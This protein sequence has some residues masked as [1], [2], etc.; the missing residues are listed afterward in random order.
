MAAFD[1]TPK[2]KIIPGPSDWGRTAFTLP[3]ADQDSQHVE[4]LRDL[5]REYHVQLRLDPIDIHNNKWQSELM[6][7]VYDASYPL[8][9]VFAMKTSVKISKDW[10]GFWEVYSQVVIPSL[11]KRMETRMEGVRARAKARA[12]ERKENFKDKG[13]S[14]RGVPIRSFHIRDNA[15]ASISSMK[16]AINRVEFQTGAQINWEWLATY[17]PLAPKDELMEII[18]NKEHWHAGVDGE[19]GVSVANMRAWKNKIATVIKVAD[20]IVGFNEIEEDKPSSIAFVLMN[21]A[22]SGIAIVRL[23]RIATSATASMIHLF[24]QCFESTRIIHTV[25]SDRM[26]ICGDG[27]LDNL[28]ARHHKLI[29]EFCESYLGSPNLCPFTLEYTHKDEYSHTVDMLMKVNSSI[30]RWRYEY[31]EKLLYTHE[32]LYKAASSRTFDE[33]IDNVLS[34]TYRDESKKWLAATCFNFFVEEIGA[35]ESSD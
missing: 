3:L 17:N 11:T 21:V 9:G 33:Y 24:C 27:F 32:K 14:L 4:S 10:L 31:Y 22:P 28:S 18:K 2:D 12:A 29:Y 30:Q 19:G 35:C 20:I 5:G 8:K 1:L 6:Q 13:V 15:A 23:P 7:D 34:D 26:F 25:A 16:K